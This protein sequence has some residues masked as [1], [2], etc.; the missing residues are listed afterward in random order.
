MQMPIC[1]TIRKGLAMKSNNNSKQNPS[2]KRQGQ[3]KYKA[4]QQETIFFFLQ[5]KVATNRMIAKATGILPRSICR[6]KRDLELS[7]LLAEV[8]K[9]YCK[10]TNKLAWYI[11]TDIDKFP[12]QTPIFDDE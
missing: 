11:T 4:T 8:K 6:H 5:D 1:L 10:V 3:Y 9:D 12:S 2:N 7:G